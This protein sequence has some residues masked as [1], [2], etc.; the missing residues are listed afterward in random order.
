[1][2]GGRDSCIALGFRDTHEKAQG[3]KADSQKQQ[4]SRTLDQLK[5][6]FQLRSAITD[7][8]TSKKLIRPLLRPRLEAPGPLGHGADPLLSSGRTELLRQNLP[9]WRG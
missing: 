1:M 8:G 5:T 3:H 9:L 6:P 4:F 7:Y 2:R